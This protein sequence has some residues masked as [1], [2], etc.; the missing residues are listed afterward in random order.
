MAAL[1]RKLRSLEGGRI[2]FFC[3]GCKENHVIQV[4]PGTSVKPWGWNRDV[5]RPTFTPS[6]LV[7]GK[8][9]ITEDEYQ[10]IKNGEDVKIP[11]LICHSFVTDGQIRFL[12]D[13]THDLA[14]QTVELPDWTNLDHEV[15]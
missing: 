10:R 7:K 5:E 3:P 6:I 12:N 11:K 9:R 14:G 8:R 4:E 2:M 13:S 1:S 15:D